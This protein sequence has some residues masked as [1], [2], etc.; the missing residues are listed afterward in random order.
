MGDDKQQQQQ[1]QLANNIAA[2]QPG[3]LPDAALPL[4]PFP[5]QSAPYPTYMPLQPVPIGSALPH[6]AEGKQARLFEPLTIRGV[7]WPNRM[8]VAPMC[9]CEWIVPAP[10]A[11]RQ[12]SIDVGS[13]SLATA[14]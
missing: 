7:A 5:A 12:T 11:A 2:Y 13:G 6:D 10:R 4:A 8:W 1:A 14:R 9:M 3:P